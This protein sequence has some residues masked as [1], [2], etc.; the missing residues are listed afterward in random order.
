MKSLR[1]FAQFVGKPNPPISPRALAE[2]L[3]LNINPNSVSMREIIELFDNEPFPLSIEGMSVEPS[4]RIVPFEVGMQLTLVRGY[5]FE[6][7][8]RILLNGQQVAVYE[9]IKPN[10]HQ[11]AHRFTE[12]GTYTVEATVKGIGST[13]YAEATKSVTVE[14]KP[15]PAP[16]PQKPDLAFIGGATYNTKTKKIEI[17]FKNI[18]TAD[19]GAFRVNAQVNNVSL[20]EVVYNGMAV[21]Q[22]DT[23]SFDPGFLDP[24]DYTYNFVLDLYNTV[25]EGNENNNG[26]NG[27]FTIPPKVP[28]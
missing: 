3:R 23:V 6:V 5:F 9:Q 13:G 11:V 25:Q 7:R 1:E 19:A 8:W 4:N 10:I 22:S 12:P 2:Y 18:G 14:A 20:G 15:K 27:T 16:L 24:G 28:S 21:G 26:F 17:S